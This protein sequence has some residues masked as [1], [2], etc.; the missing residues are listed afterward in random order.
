MLP[1][2]C[3][4]YEYN[5]ARLSTPCPPSSGYF[6]RSKLVHPS[7]LICVVELP[8]Q[9]YQDLNNANGFDHD[10]PMTRGAAKFYHNHTVRLNFDDTLTPTPILHV[11]LGY[12]WQ[13]EP[14]L[15]LPYDQSKPKSAFPPQVSLTH[16]LIRT[17]TPPLQASP[18]E[19]GAASVRVASVPRRS[20]RLRM[21]ESQPPISTSPG[22]RITT[23]TSSVAT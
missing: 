6:L 15:A 8:S 3:T 12:F 1:T 21:D 4:Q 5:A 17:P 9:T 18:A 20:T 23:R 14:N 2:S 13:R 22:S 11:G 10:V 7:S 19:S 16:F